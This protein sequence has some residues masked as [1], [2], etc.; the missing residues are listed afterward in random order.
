MKWAKVL[1][2]ALISSFHCF[3][4]GYADLSEN[5]VW[6]P[7]RI[8]ATP[9]H[10][11]F[12][13]YHF[14][15]LSKLYLEWSKCYICIFWKPILLKIKMLFANWLFST[16]TK[17]QINP[18]SQFWDISKILPVALGI[19]LSVYMKFQASSHLLKL[20]SLDCV[21]PSRKPER[22]FSHDAAHILSL[23]VCYQ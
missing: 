21:G 5:F 15:R 17:F 14:L 10:H 4:G 6:I 11:T 19:L 16:T 1:R 20:Y 18:K 13:F 23:I 7:Q 8:Q 12:C 9:Y 3:V 22:W 2:R